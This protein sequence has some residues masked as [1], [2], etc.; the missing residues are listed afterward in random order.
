VAARG[1][2]LGNAFL[3]AAIAIPVWYHLKGRPSLPLCCG[4][5]S[6]ALGLSFVATFSQVF[7]DLAAFLALVTWALALDRR[8]R[9]FG[10]CVL[11]GLLVTLIFCGYPLA[12][13]PKGELFYGAHS[14]REMWQSL[15]QVSFYQFYPPFAH[16]EF[17]KILNSLR[18]WLAPALGVFCIL[19]IVA[20]WLD[21]SWAKDANARWLRTLAI[22]LLSITGLCVLLHWMAYRLDVFPLPMTRTGIFLI[23]LCTLSAA[24]I[25]A[26]PARFPISRAIRRCITGVFACIACYLL[27]CLRLTYFQEYRDDADTKEIYAVLAKINH[28]YGVTDTAMDGLYVAPLN[29]YRVM[30]KKETFPEFQYVSLDDF[31]KGKSIYILHGGYF[32]EFIKNERL[33]IVYRG[34][35][36]EVVVA[37]KPD[38]AI[39]PAMIE[40]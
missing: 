9:I 19:Q 5:A 29:F 35:L 8:P 17:Y 13:W 7:V 28:A 10:Y 2:S 1:Y 15:V 24:V 38:G 33:A 40:P 31:P 12:H 21:G 26:G 11:P 4:L 14:L 34:K 37:V 16:F 3:L 25:G 22:S 32:R 6:L 20:T 23:P 27:L 30:S 39:P 36:S 18:P